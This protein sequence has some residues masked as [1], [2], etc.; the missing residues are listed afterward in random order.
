[1]LITWPAYLAL[2]LAVG[3]SK[4]AEQKSP[5]AKESAP[6]QSVAAPSA[7]PGKGTIMGKVVFMGSQRPGKLSVG[8]DREVCGD[9]KPDPSL[10]VGGNGELKNAVV[11]IAGL[12]EGVTPS[13]DAL[14]D[15]MKCEYLPH[16][17]VV[18]A[19]ATVTFKNSDGILHNIHTVSQ[20]NSPFNR[21]Q[22]KF[23]KELK[24][25]FAKPEVIALR[26]DVHGWMS[27]WI[28]VT[29]NVY[30]AVTETDGSF[31]L[32]DVPA[33]KYSLEVWH[34]TLGSATQSVELKAGET[35]NVNIEFSANK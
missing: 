5:P 28:V 30:F 26:C 27:G 7:A 14:V 25:N 3:C 2:L 18:P 10:I 9:G 1:M 23:L 20:I 29:D 13:K 22:P 12:R 6:A 11:Q 16:V 24:E 21:A 31:K 19:G 4:E 33:G 35:A 17:T 32:T 15:Q 8:K 34:E